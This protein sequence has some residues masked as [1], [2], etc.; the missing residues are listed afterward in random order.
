[1]L[2]VHVDDYGIACPRVIGRRQD[3]EP[4]D[5]IAAMIL[6]TH[7]L[8]APVLGHRERCLE[9]AQRDGR[10]AARPTACG[11]KDELPGHVR[12][13]PPDPRERPSPRR[14]Q[15]PVRRHAPGELRDGAG[16]HI[17]CRH[18]CKHPVLITDHAGATVR[19]PRKIH[20]STAQLTRER[21]HRTSRHRNHVNRIEA[22]PGAE[23]VR[24]LPAIRR[25][26][27]EPLPPRPLRQPR[28]G[29]RAHVE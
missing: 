1:M 17:D 28:H 5:R 9:R 8:L 25:P 21:V 3:D 27:G 29:M 13:R 24:H 22:V 18:R 16:A 14:G 4:L 11:P 7:D 10:P 26:L 6:P 20:D 12:V 23:V 15:R 19:E 2:T